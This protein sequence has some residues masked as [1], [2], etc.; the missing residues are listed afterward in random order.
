MGLGHCR[1][2][3]S[4]ICINTCSIGIT[5][6]V[7]LVNLGLQSERFFFLS[8]VCLTPR[9]SFFLLGLWLVPSSLFLLVVTSLVLRR[10][11]HSY[12]SGPC[13]V[14]LTLFSADSWWLRRRNLLVAILLGRSLG[15]LDLPLCPPI[16]TLYWSASHIASTILPLLGVCWED[17]LLASC[18]IV[19]QW[20][21]KQ[22]PCWVARS[23]Q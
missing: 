4:F 15:W 20:N 6:G 1:E 2:G 18:V 23:S 14:V 7:K 10:P 11:L 21:D 12:T 9:V 19:L 8:K 3:S 5:K 17:A 13:E 22:N 16:A